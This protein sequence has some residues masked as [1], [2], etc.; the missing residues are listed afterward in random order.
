MTRQFEIYAPLQD[1][2]W[3]GVDFELTPEL[4]IRHFTE[5]PDLQ[6]LAA[7]I[8]QDEQTDVFFYAQHWLT[9]NWNE[10]TEPSPAET[11]N[12]VL[13]ALWLTKP[14][15]THV[16]LRFELGR[17]A[18]AGENNRSRLFDRFA[19]IPGA[20]QEEFNRSDLTSASSYYLALR[21]ICCARGRLNDA[22]I[23]TL[24]GCWSHQWQTSLICHAAAAEALLTYST[25]PGIT[26]R[27][28]MS[29]ACLIETQ[30]TSRDAAYG[31][32]RRLYSVRS[33]IMHGRTGNVLPSERLPFLARVQDVLR[34][35]WRTIISS[36]QTVSVLEDSDAQREAYFNQLTSGYK[37]PP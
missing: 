30:R 21:D 17:N 1:F 22:F 4:R 9:F 23:L 19:W 28:A 16:S 27:L 33:D 14:T 5:K 10:G 15:R 12:L 3:D 37:P 31:E 29:Y 36:P 35:L 11:V 24:T 34:M 7:T 26:R 20:T 13:V 8:D 2:Y 25:A 32:F 18:A 6:G